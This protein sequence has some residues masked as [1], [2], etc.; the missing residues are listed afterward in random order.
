ML[1]KPLKV[2]ETFKSIKYVFIL[3]LE[4][5][6]S[7][8][9]GTGSHEVLMPDPFIV[10]FTSLLLLVP[11]LMVVGGIIYVIRD[12]ELCFSIFIRYNSSITNFPS[13]ARA[14]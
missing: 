4:K 12:Y 8:F 9:V 6:R 2:S 5:E 13:S 10:R 7:S 14:I 11:H 1:T 3:S